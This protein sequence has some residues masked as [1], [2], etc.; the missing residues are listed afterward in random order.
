ML[1]Q[2]HVIG[3]PETSACCLFN[4]YSG[5][6]T[7]HRLLRVQGEKR[8]NESGEHNEACAPLE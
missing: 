7:S 6:N 8:I 1:E 2:C 3:G 5:Q 4:L